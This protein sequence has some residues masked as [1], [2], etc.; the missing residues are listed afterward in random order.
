MTAWIISSSVLILG[1][2]ILRRVLRGKISLRL[3]YALWLVVL[4]R[5]LCPLNFFESSLSVQN[6]VQSV[7]NRTQVQTS[8]VEVDDHDLPGEPGSA[9]AQTSAEIP[10]ANREQSA[11]EAAVPQQSP[12]QNSGQA[13]VTEPAAPGRNWE[14][15]GMTIWLAGA[16]VM[17]SFTFGCNFQFARM[18]ARNR[19][20]VPVPETRVQV[21]VSSWVKTPCLVGIFRPVIYLTPEVAADRSSWNH[22]ISHELTHLDHLDH[23]FS[24]LRCVALCLH[25]YNPL[26]WL[27]ARI[28]KEDAE[29]A[30]DEGTIARLG[31]QERIG[32]GETLIRLTCRSKNP[33]DLMLTA[34][35]M[36]GTQGGIRERIKCLAKKPKTL[37]Y[38]M[39]V[40]MI[41]VVLMVGCTFSSPVKAEEYHDPAETIAPSETAPP[42][43]TSLPEETEASTETFTL[44]LPSE[45]LYAFDRLSLELQNYLRG[46]WEETHLG[47]GAAQARYVITGFIEPEGTEYATSQ[48]SVHLFQMDFDVYLNDN[49]EHHTVYALFW[50]NDWGTMEHYYQYSNWEE[51]CFFEEETLSWFDR[52]EYVAAYGNKYAAAVVAG[53]ELFGETLQDGKTQLLAFMDRLAESDGTTWCSELPDY[54][55]PMQESNRQALC[56]GA[57]EYFSWIAVDTDPE[58]LECDYVELTLE[59]GDYLLIYDWEWGFA[60]LCADGEISRYQAS[61]IVR[62]E[63]TQGRDSYYFAFAFFYGSYIAF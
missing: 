9:G 62:Y 41:A 32:Y 10:D 38:A 5:L 7:Q 22:V 50:K 39:A 20:E 60:E 18:L 36:I 43:E 21:Y 1:I 52:P 42:A 8:T 51:I 48:T 57:V 17:L 13:N 2:L 31:E 49:Q 44:D 34:T 24:T 33:G 59:D 35:T 30:C 23:A 55:V 28:S 37:A 26:V 4:I 63:V 19:Q 14:Q 6:A 53:A 47:D 54:A 40:S 58:T 3:Q 56:R 25:W 45:E 12:A 46:S 11:P 27:A 15:I 61:P 29:L 16:L